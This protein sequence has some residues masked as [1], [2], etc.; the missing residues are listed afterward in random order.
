M[1]DD[2]RAQTKAP[3][4]VLG[5]RLPDGGTA[6]AVSG[7]AD[8]VIGAPLTTDD[9]FRIGS[10]T[11]T[12]VATVILQLQA[13]GRLDV[14]DNL[15]KYLPAA[16]HAD[17]ITLRQLLDHTSGLAD[18]A[19]QPGYVISILTAPGRRWTA[20]DTIDVISGKPLKFEPG[21]RWNYSNTNYVLL[22]QVAEEVTGTPLAQLL[23]ERIYQPLGL[24]STYLEEEEDAPPI[25]VA[26]HFDLNGDGEAESVRSIPY[27]AIVT[28]GAA[29]GGISASALD[30]LDF[31]SGL[32]D[33]V[34]L[35]QNSLDDMLTIDEPSTTYGLGIA[36][37]DFGS[38]EAW[39]HA[40]A[41]PG[42]SAIFLR[43]DDGTIAVA[44]ASATDLDVPAL[45]RSAARAVA[46]LR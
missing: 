13:E 4:A 10:I 34:L 25:R 23:R 33:G 24:D 12:F 18:F 40:G 2:W 46:E 45:V 21:S 26:G 30:V 17:Q 5:F 35:D 36:R 1:V 41:I 20:Q 8:E 38:H 37:R 31:A 15:S 7:E 22:G 28:S 16:P 44:M 9:R 42:F 11:K 14:A 19:V 3:A 27:T 43:A 32:F 29:A 39:G 6:V